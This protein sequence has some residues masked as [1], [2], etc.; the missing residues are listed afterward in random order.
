MQRD[1]FSI[2]SQVAECLKY[3][4]KR[5]YSVIGNQY[6]DP[7]TGFDKMQGGGAIPA[8]VDD[9]TSRELSSPFLINQR[10]SIPTGRMNSVDDSIV[11]SRSA[12]QV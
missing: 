8:F 12:T 6:V 5:G 2:P 11:D 7:G 3:A 9:F 10:L 4:E 1:N